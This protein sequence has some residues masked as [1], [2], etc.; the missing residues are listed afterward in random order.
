MKKRSRTR[1]CRKLITR[2]LE[3]KNRRVGESKKWGCLGRFKYGRRN[4]R[5]T[6]R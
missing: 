6:W 4:R 1:R 2:R 5:R 3:M